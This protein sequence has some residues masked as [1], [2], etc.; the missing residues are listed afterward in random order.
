MTI[1]HHIDNRVHHIP[2]LLNLTTSS[3][4]YHLEFILSYHLLSSLYHNLENK[5]TGGELAPNTLAPNTL[6]PSTLAPSTL[7]PST[8]GA[9][10]SI[11]ANWRQLAVGVSLFIT[12][13]KRQLAVPPITAKIWRLNKI[14]D[15]QSAPIG[16]NRRQ[17]TVK[18]SRP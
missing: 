18:G 17:F 10:I 14:G 3:K 16:S 11:G 9:K 6:A 7:A 15:R 1:F 4:F 5:Y 8:I 12:G 2:S 13:I